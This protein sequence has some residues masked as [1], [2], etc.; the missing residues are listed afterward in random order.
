MARIKALLLGGGGFLGSGLQNAFKKKNID[1]TVLD[2][3]RINFE[4]PSCIYDL[5]NAITEFSH[6]FILAS[7]I[8]ARL[9][10]TNPVA[11]G[12]SNLRIY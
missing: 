2:K 12:L 10:E 9:F 5:S 4:D 11:A 8:G 6:V 1:F 3:D 7:K